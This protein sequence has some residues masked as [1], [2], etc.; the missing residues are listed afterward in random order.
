MSLSREKLVRGAGRLLLELLVVFIGVYLAFLLSEHRAERERDA[1]R[2]QLQAALASE[3]AFFTEGADRI[4]PAFDSLYV[5]WQAG[6][7]AG[8]QPPPLWFQLTGVSMPPRGMWQAVLASDAVA[9]LDVATMQTVSGF[10]NALDVL[11]KAY[12]ELDDFAQREIIPHEAADEAIF[13]DADGRLKPHYQDYMRRVQNALRLFDIV[14][15]MATESQAM[16]V[17]EGA[18]ASSP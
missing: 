12:D 17:E 10:Y 7:E 1:R 6:F 16:L 8:E 18:G 4:A 3:I 13:Y 5:D 15:E 2:D 14:Q 9:T 11:L